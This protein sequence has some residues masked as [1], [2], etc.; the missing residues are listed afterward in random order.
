M[1]DPAVPSV[2]QTKKPVGLLTDDD[3]NRSSMRLMSF[4]ALIASIGFGWIAIGCSSANS[5]VGIYITSV[6]V[7]AAFA[8]KALQKYIEKS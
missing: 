2:L 4:I 1:T 3:G 8:P 5:D 6:F 7:L